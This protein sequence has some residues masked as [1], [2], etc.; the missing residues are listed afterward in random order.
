MAFDELIEQTSKGVDVSEVSV[1]NDI[2]V[3]IREDGSLLSDAGVV[4]RHQQHVVSGL[5][6]GQ[7]YIDAVGRRHQ[8]VSDLVAV[9]EHLIRASLLECIGQDLT[10]HFDHVLCQWL[11]RAEAASGRVNVDLSLIHI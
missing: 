2:Q 8:F 11:T 6:L 3:W 4:G 5:V 7:T 9:D 1:F 10:N